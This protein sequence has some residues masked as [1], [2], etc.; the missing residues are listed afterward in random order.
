MRKKILM[1]CLTLSSQAYGAA[2]KKAYN[3]I[4]GRSESVDLVKSAEAKVAKEA[5]EQN[6]VEMRNKTSKVTSAVKSAENRVSSFLGVGKKSRSVDLA[7]DA[8]Q[9]MM[10]ARPTSEPI[11][12]GTSPQPPARAVSLDVSKLQK[13]YDPISYAKD[14][15][16]GRPK[17]EA[18]VFTSPVQSHMKD[19]RIPKKQGPGVVTYSSK[20]DPKNDNALEFEENAV[21]DKKPEDL[22]KRGYSNDDVNLLISRNATSAGFVKNLAQ[23]YPEA[24]SQDTMRLLFKKN[25]SNSHNTTILKDLPDSMYAWPKEDINAPANQIKLREYLSKPGAVKDNAFLKNINDDT[26]KELVKYHDGDIQKRFALVDVFQP[27][28]EQNPKLKQDV[29]NDMSD[30]IIGSYGTEPQKQQFLSK[31]IA[32]QAQDSQFMR[33]YLENLNAKE[34]KY[35]RDNKNTLDLSKSLSDADLKALIAAKSKQPQSQQVLQDIYGA[36]LSQQPEKVAP[37]LSPQQLK[38]KKTVQ[39]INNND[40][41]TLDESIATAKGQLEKKANKPAVKAAA[42]AKADAARAKEAE[43]AQPRTLS[44][45]QKDKLAEIARIFD[46]KYKP[47]SSTASVAHQETAAFNSVADQLTVL[48]EKYANSTSRIEKIQLRKEMGEVLKTPGMTA[49]ERAQFDPWDSL[50]NPK[51]QADS[52]ENNPFAEPSSVVASKQ[53]SGV[54]AS[55]A[56]SLA[57]QLAAV[58]LK[59][60]TAN[61]AEQSALKKILDGESPDDLP[62]PPA[63][64]INPK[65]VTGASAPS[66]IPVAPPLPGS[67]AVSGIPTPPALPSSV[68]ASAVTTKAPQVAA[69]KLPP[70]KDQ[71]SAL[72]DQIKQGKELKSVNSTVSGVGVSAGKNG[73]K[74]SV[75]T[76]INRKLTESDHKRIL[77]T[78]LSGMND[79]IER[80]QFI[81]TYNDQNGT[82]FKSEKFQVKDEW[83]SEA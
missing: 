12:Q 32:P 39:N 22:K 58:K 30:D 51:K 5:A 61:S 7:Q 13:S 67:A 2:I 83:A 11:K 66:G 74:D 75:D 41:K 27:R 24:I 79:P 3:A 72:L 55:A 10:R 71:R 42:K 63:D 78:E 62:Q 57:D 77:E 82:K 15:S 36:R 28:M 43:T 48:G 17:I 68:G 4:R 49:N 65:S 6:T 47:S 64:S 8:G 45:A 56:P 16:A 20:L 14:Q 31:Y 73:L 33:G 38:F 52:M 46:K 59:P 9:D 21:L 40:L 44:E 69:S 80:A 37:G 76:L 18:P 23:A 19:I 35:L 60:V 26:V 54:G 70:V 81:K 53:P 29:L 50:I 34:L 25:E 1:L